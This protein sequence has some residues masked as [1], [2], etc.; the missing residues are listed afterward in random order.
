MPP[1]FPFSGVQAQP[2]SVLYNGAAQLG[3]GATPLVVASIFPT[4]AIIGGADITLEVHGQFESG[5]TILFNGGAETTVFVNSGKLTTIVKPSTAGTPGRYPIQV[6]RGSLRSHSCMFSFLTGAP[7]PTG[8]T[9][10]PN[11]CTDAF[12]LAPVKGG[13]NASDDVVYG[14]P[15]VSLPHTRVNLFK[16]SCTVA[17]ELA[18]QQLSIK[19]KRG[20]LYSPPVTVTVETAPPP[21]DTEE[22]RRREEQPPRRSRDE[23]ES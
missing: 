23:A 7:M 9:A 10:T 19:I 8:L 13:F 5:D 3:G 1:Q 6:K 21:G 11:P 2:G 16:M 18:G 22:T 4:F 20:A 14:T 17:P 12:D 15:E